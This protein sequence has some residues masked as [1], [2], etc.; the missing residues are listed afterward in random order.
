[1]PNPTP[2]KPKDLDDLRRLTARRGKNRELNWESIFKRFPNRT[3][4]S[5]YKQIYSHGWCETDLWTPEEDRILLD[6]WNDR[7]MRKMLESLP[8][9]TRDSIYKR[10]RKLGLRAGPPQGMVSVKSLSTDPLWGYDYYKTLKILQFASVQ[11]RRFNYA[12]KRKGIKYVDPDG[13][14]AAAAVWE[15]HVASERVG[16]ETTKEAARR[17][18]VREDTLRAWVTRE[19]LIRPSDPN[20]KRRFFAPPEV[21]DRIAAK[22]RRPSGQR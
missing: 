19:G 21:F 5:I 2:W 18:Q 3:R 10:A 7:P 4:S 6:G 17:I 14:R 12:G 11:T 1:M 16:K 15:K 8:N 22:Y 13:A 20:T 9:R